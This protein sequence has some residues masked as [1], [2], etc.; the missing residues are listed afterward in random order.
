VRTTDRITV[1][2]RS[3]IGLLEAVILHRPGAEVSQMTPATA[4][5]ALYS[6]ILNLAV[7]SHE[8]EQIEGV[9]ARSARAFQVRDLLQEI[10]ADEQV[11]QTL[12]ER[13]CRH[14]GVPDLAAALLPLSPAE[15]TRNL[16]EGVPLA[17]DTLTRFLSKER[18]ALPPL[19]NFFFAR[20]AAMVVGAQV[21]LGRMASRVRTR[22]SL[23]MEAIFE[24]HP[25]LAAPPLVRLVGDR[26]DETIEGGDLLVAREDVLLIGIGARTSPQAVDALVER[27]AA[28]PSPRHVLVQELPLRPESF[29]HLDMVFTLIDRDA[30]VVHAPLLLEHNH[31]ETVQIQVDNGRVARIREVESLLH[32]LRALGIDLEPIVC[33]G[34]DDR[35]RQEREQW[36]SGT[37]LFAVAPGKVL[38]YARNE[39][40]LAELDRRGFAVLPAAD[41]I[42]GRADPGAHRRCVI[43][44]GGSELARG[45]GG[46]RCM[47]L[48]LRRASVR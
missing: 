5:H 33:G 16:I 20:D 22:E 48:P 35:W 38:G 9:L 13:V 17:R 3:E 37:N 1:D 6:D 18:F 4:A 32:G 39:H 15:L 8:H 11:K 36:H 29:I 27:L 25:L 28:D 45:G 30:C 43:T 26:G 23:I 19:H 44:V 10:L 41:V 21:V 2:I 31:Y 46:C 24:A 47:T 12:V 14:E 7:A 42:A 40:T 34:T